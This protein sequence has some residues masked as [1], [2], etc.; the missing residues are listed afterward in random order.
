MTVRVREAQYA[1][2]LR[3]E[4]SS[5]LVTANLQTCIAFSGINHEKGVVFLCHLNSP[6]CAGKLLPSLVADL[7][8]RG[9]CLNDFKLYTSIGVNPWPMVVAAT[10]F[11]DALLLSLC[12]LP[13]FSFASLLVF[14]LATAISVIYFHLKRLGL[15]V[16]L[17][18]ARAHKIERRFLGYKFLIPIFFRSRVCVDANLEV[19]VLPKVRRYCANAGDRR[20]LPSSDT[21]E[22]KAKGSA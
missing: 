18:R 21:T 17:R 19:K 12:K 8:K 4:S 5:K 22:K 16:T 13:I 7:K 10:I 11:I 1:I 14:L 15:Y 20:Y 2:G 6:W 3:G 9:L